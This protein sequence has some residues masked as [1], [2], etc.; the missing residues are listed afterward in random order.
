MGWRIPDD[1]IETTRPKPRARIDGR[2]RVVSSIG[3]MAS[4]LER[5]PPDGGIRLG[6][7]DGR[8]PAGVEDYDLD[9]AE[10]L[11][12]RHGNLR[13]SRGIGGVAG[14]RRH[15]DFVSV[16]DLLGR[17]LEG[18]APTRPQDQAAAFGSESLGTGPPEPG[19][20]AAHEGGSPVETQVH[21]PLLRSTPVNP[22]TEWPP[23]LG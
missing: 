14:H 4:E 13:R 19:R 23:P 16:S 5:A 7:L 1:S 8:R 10:S 17:K 11:P 3:V 20:G 18:I 2:R 22:P 9:L 21:I 6:R 12:G 15:V